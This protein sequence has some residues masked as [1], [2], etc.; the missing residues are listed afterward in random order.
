MAQ[1]TIYINS[2]LESKV[3]KIASS[4]NISISKYIAT[5]VEKNIEDSWNPKV[6]KLAVSWSDFPTIEE[7][8][9]SSAKDIKREEF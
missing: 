1:I 3:K 9:N 5:I 2:E 7:I 4:L 8:R 6:K